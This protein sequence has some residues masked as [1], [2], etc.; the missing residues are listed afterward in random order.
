MIWSFA[1]SSF[2]WPAWINAAVLLLVSFFSVAALSLQ[3]RP[4]A[5]IIAVAFPPWWSA[6]E[7]FTAAAWANAE[8]VRTTTVPAV[9]IVKP[10]VDGG[11]NRLRAAGA[12]L[13]FDPRAAAACF[14]SQKEAI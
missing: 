1:R 3:A 10:D 2:G 7:S 14:K 13:I 6:Q 4:G 11:L 9:L 8:I 5:E 12:W